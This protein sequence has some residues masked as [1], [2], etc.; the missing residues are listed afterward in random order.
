[1]F[2]LRPAGRR[3]PFATRAALCMGVPVL[4][5][6]AASDV[7][8]GLMATIG[9]FTALYGSER[10]YLNR[11]VYL[12]VIAISFAVAVT[13]GVWAAELPLM[14]V[15][16]VVLISM[17][18][19]FLC[20]ALRVGPPGAYMFALAC[21]AGT[22]MPVG[23]LTL[24]QI[25]LLVF[26]GGV[27]AWLAH[28]AGAFVSPRGPERAAVAAAARAV[29]RFVETA[30][31]PGADS[32]RHNAALA[33]H[34]SWT[35]LVTHQPARPR[36]DGTLSRL[37]A[38]NRELNL[39]FVSII[40]AAAGPSLSIVA[41]RARSLAAQAMD[42]SADMEHTDPGH[43][44]LGHYGFLESL[45]G[46]L[47]PWSPPLLV[48][49]RVGIATFIAGVI[50]AVLDLERA[51]WTMAAAVL[52]LHQ[53]LDWVRSLQRGVERMSGTMVGLILAGA[54]LAIHPEGLWLVLTLMLIQFT[55][56][57]TVIRN[58]ALAVVFIT[59]AALTIA[60]GGH[61]VPDVGH[62]LWV[63]GTDT[64]IGCV[65]GLAV[66]VMTTP[67]TAA[68]RIPQELVNTLAA[69]RTVLDLTAGGDVTHG[70]ARQAR[71][72]LQHRTIVLLQAYEAA[73]GA[74]PW[75]RDAAERAWP[76]VV[77]AQRLAYRV[78][79]TCWSLENAQAGAAPEMARTLF[80]PD[81]RE[82]AGHALAILSRA[83]HAGA[84][85]APLS[86]VPE[87]LSTEMQNLHGSLVYAGERPVE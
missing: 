55:I 69:V 57:M 81:G 60:A 40:N 80:G 51:Y 38:I 84:R 22:A 87:F 47:R 32:A 64:F 41:E 48:A 14:I 86:P 1:M 76:A 31:T 73:V 25:G 33:M 13:L 42:A 5:G 11:A 19:T 85:P 23:H 68:V 26:G 61:P 24:L 18:A 28:M 72:D 65:I 54:I 53:G 39:I 62:M 56:E 46:N 9:A 79:A 29:A 67:R 12:A 15:P 17:V 16:T 4:A 82:N 6:W 8:A 2:R 27:F 37:R 75:H 3:W 43:V 45:K 66:L 10:P 71:R 21:A 78:L 59:T 35:V 77:A 30:D 34:E 20:N 58:Y 52:M 36:P 83:I 44:P 70:A 7:T 49:A 50:G 74:T 63:R